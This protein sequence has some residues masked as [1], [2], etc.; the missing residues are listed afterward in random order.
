MVNIV[1]TPK[2]AS[3][4]SLANLPVADVSTTCVA[5]TPAFYTVGIPAMNPSVALNQYVMVK[6]SLQNAVGATVRT[7]RVLKQNGTVLFSFTA[8]TQPA[9]PLQSVTIFSKRIIVTNVADW[10]GLTIQVSS[11]TAGDSIIIKKDS[12]LFAYAESCNIID[13]RMVKRNVENLYFMCMQTLEEGILGKVQSG[14]DT[15][16]LTVPVNGLVNGFE[17][18]TNS[19]NTLYSWSGSSIGIG[20]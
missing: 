6:L 12:L 1:I 7:V 9:L 3:F 4:G 10:V 19:G 2:A 17:W 11:T 5:V 20:A 13:E 8:I 18:S 16:F 14:S 15:S